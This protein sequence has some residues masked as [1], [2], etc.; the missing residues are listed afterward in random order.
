MRGGNYTAK[1]QYQLQH[2]IDVAV[3]IRFI[4]FL[5]LPLSCRTKTDTHT[6]TFSHPNMRA[7]TCEVGAIDMG[8]QMC[9]GKG[10]QVGVGGAPYVLEL[11][12]TLL[13]KQWCLGR[14]S[15]AHPLGPEA[16]WASEGGVVVVVDSCTGTADIAGTAGIVGTVGTAGTVGSTLHSTWYG[17][18]SLDVLFWQN[19]KV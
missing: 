7:Y 6:H 9:V 12:H 15:V 19:K 5:Q 17:E 4:P 8:T 10:N 3:I 14:T 13:V 16:S 11:A 1:L 18:K 2:Q